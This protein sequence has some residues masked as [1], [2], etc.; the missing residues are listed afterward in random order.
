MQLWLLQS[1]ETCLTAASQTLFS[2]SEHANKHVW[3]LVSQSTQSFPDGAFLVDTVAVGRLFYAVDSTWISHAFSVM[4][5]VLCYVRGTIDGKRNIPSRASF[6][7]SMLSGNSD[8]LQIRAITPESALRTC[9]P[10]QPRSTSVIVRLIRLALDIFEGVCQ[11]PTFHPAR[12]FQVIVKNA[13]SLVLKEE[14]AGPQESQVIDDAALQSLLD[15]INESG[16]EWPMNLFD[17]NMDYS[18]GWEV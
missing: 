17:P 10:K 5:I 9:S 6:W 12:D 4:F 3:K 1:L 16:L 8:D 11:T 7:S 14:T 15:S 18:L 2:L 13:A